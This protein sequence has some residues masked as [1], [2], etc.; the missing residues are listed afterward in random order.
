MESK[1]EGKDEVVVNLSENRD[2]AHTCGLLSLRDD[3]KSIKWYR[4]IFVGRE[5]LVGPIFNAIG[6][7]DRRG[8]FLVSGYRGA[9]KTSLVPEAALRAR[10]RLE[11]D[12]RKLL[13]LILNVSEVSASLD[14]PKEVQKQPLRI[15]ACRLLTALLRPL[16][17]QREAIAR[18]VGD[19]GKE[20]ARLLKDKKE[21]EPWREKTAEHTGGQDDNPA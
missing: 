21:A 5:A 20:L 15:D 12:D 17:N 16:S 2:A 4:P 10:E 11:S 19:G 18:N 3:E 13:P 14:T 7:P 6:L 1:T 8:T 9:G